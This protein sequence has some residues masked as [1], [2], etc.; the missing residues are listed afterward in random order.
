MT[1]RN[2]ILPLLA[3]GGLTLAVSVALRS[4][5]VTPPAQPVAQPSRAPF[6]AYVGGSGIVEASSDNIAVG[7]P[8]G[9]VVRA[10]AVKVGRRVAAGDLLF[11]IDD[12]DRRAELAQKQAA[13]AK[14]RASLEEAEASCRDY[15]TQYRLVSTVTDPRA[16]SLDDLEKRRNAMYL[17][18]AKVKSAQ[19]DVAVAEADLAAARTALDLLG[20]RAPIDGE[21]LQVNVR[22]GEYAAA[23][24]LDTPLLRLGD[25]DTL[26]VRVDIDENDAWRF[27]PGARAVAFLRGN[28]DFKVFLDYVRTEPYVRPKT[29]LSGSSTEQVDTRVLQV[30]YAFR[31]AD[32]PAAY[33]GQQVDAFIEARPIVSSMQAEANATAVESVPAS[34]GGTEL[35]AGG[36]AGAGTPA[37]AGG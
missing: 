15:E 5:R 20:V 17:Y 7:T 27:E 23:G 8:V 10:V 16:V 11:E 21:I 6:A 30:V 19:A 22:P 18:R 24:V 9:G 32:L 26:H 35:P 25:M 33:V 4:Q 28:R 13:L 36:A 29:Q 14:A 3:L 1:L 31:R 2:K 34:A 37:G 12:R